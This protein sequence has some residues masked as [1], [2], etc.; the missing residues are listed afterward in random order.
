MRVSNSYFSYDETLKGKFISQRR[1]WSKM[2]SE[3]ME[4][5][6]HSRGA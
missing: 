1:Q 3:Q 5:I 6:A 2:V 4:E